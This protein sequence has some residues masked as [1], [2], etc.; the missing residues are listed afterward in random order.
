MNHACLFTRGLSWLP[1]FLLQYLPR[2]QL[3]LNC[4]LTA[5]FN[6]M[7]LTPGICHSFHYAFYRLSILIGHFNTLNQSIGYD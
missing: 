7:S 2:K 5:F 4:F 6:I 1:S 3:Y